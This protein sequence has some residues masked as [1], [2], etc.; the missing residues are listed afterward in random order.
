[1]HFHKDLFTVPHLKMPG[2]IQNMV[3]GIEPMQ[4]SDGS[5]NF[6]T[7]QA[8]EKNRNRRGVWQAKLYMS[9]GGTVT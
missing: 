2:G 5:V 1:M 6:C 3:G 8:V 7:L 9:T 4:V